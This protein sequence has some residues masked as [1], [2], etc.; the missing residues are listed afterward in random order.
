MLAFLPRLS[1]TECS[2]WINLL[3]STKWQLIIDNYLDSVIYPKANSSSMFQST[4]TLAFFLYSNEIEFVLKLLPLFHN[5]NVMELAKFKMDCT[6]SNINSRLFWWIWPFDEFDHLLVH[7]KTI[8]IYEIWTF[9]VSFCSFSSTIFCHEKVDK[10]MY[11][12][13]SW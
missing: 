3:S 8:I 11:L 6:F 12:P 1:S 5:L 7:M 2:N 10:F 9:Y 4:F 13:Q